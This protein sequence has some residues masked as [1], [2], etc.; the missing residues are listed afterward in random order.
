M[1]NK[2]AIETLRSIIEYSLDAG[3]QEIAIS[4]LD[5]L[6]AHQQPR[7][8]T[9]EEAIAMAKTEAPRYSNNPPLT[10]YITIGERDAWMHG[11]ATAATTAPDLILSGGL[12]VDEA[13]EVAREVQNAPPDIENMTSKFSMLEPALRARLAA[14]LQ[15]Q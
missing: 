6:E 5:Q 14:K 7:R 9:W 13:M 4:A 1:S 15:G 10:R 8:L 11:Y 3:D 2:T 12:S